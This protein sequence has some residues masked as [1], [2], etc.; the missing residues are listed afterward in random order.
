[1]AEEAKETVESTQPTEQAAEAQKEPKVK[2]KK[3]KRSVTAGNLY[4]Q[5]TFNNTLITFT[6]AKGNV[7]GWSSAGAKG[8][9]GARKGTPFAAQIAT[10]DAARKVM[11]GYG[12]KTVSEYVKGPGAGRE[13]ALRALQSVG[14]RVT[15]IKDLTPIPHNGCRPSKRRRV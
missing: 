8:F 2:K 3:I 13:A 14:L 15:Y 1:M 6:D 12:L 11:D 4:I 10:E 5:A 7:L 9:K